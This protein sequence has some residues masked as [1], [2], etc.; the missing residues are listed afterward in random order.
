[1]QVPEPFDLVLTVRSHGW[2]DLPPWRWDEA[3][4]VL[5]RPLRLSGARVAY[6]EVAE[7]EPGRLAFRAFAQGRLGAAEAREARALLGACLALD[8]DLGPFQAL[9]AELERRRAAGKGRDLPDLRWALARGAGRL[10]RSP[11]VYEDAVKTLCTTNCSWALT[12][13]MV[14]RLCETLG[15]PG[16]LGTRAF[17]TPE[18]MAAR[19]ERFYREEIRAGYRAPFLLALARGAAD[20]TLELEGLR[21][22]PLDTDALGR[23]ISELKG[24]GPYATEHLLRLLGRHDHL[25]LDSWTRPKLARLRGKRR[26]PADRTLRRWFAPYG[27]WAG[28]AMWLEVTADWHGDAPS[29]P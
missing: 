22:S 21:R 6:A 14:T 16:P 19:T 3:R 29:W 8:E 13:S 28:L 11:T 7:G 12:R 24:F 26:P 1:M 4:R 27:R 18:A 2:Y 20:G 5:G 25:A 9:A 17:P 10:L 15:E 23:R